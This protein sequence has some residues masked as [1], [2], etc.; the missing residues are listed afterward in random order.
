MEQ[1]QTSNTATQESHHK[2]D[3][4]IGVFK[5]TLLDEKVATQG[6]G[7]GRDGGP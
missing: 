2:Q 6:H 1:P 7:M 4:G 5:E 3:R